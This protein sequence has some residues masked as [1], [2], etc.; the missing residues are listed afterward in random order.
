VV[1]AIR[2]AFARAREE[3]RAALVPFLTAG[4][5]DREACLELLLGMADVGADVVELGVPFSDP[6]ADGPT[7]QRASERALAGGMSLAGALDL[8]AAFR[9]RRE[10]P[11]V[12]FTY[13]NPVLRR[14]VSATARELAR[15]GA[16]GVLVCDLPAGEA[17]EVRAEFR[18][19][20]L[21][22]VAL[23]AP[24]SPEARLRSVAA[25]SSGF[26]YLIGRT[27]VTGAG[28]A[29]P[30]LER[31]LAALRRLTDLPV[32][33]GFGIAG[34]ESARAVARIADG[35]VVGSALLDRIDGAGPRAG[36]DFLR[37][38]RAALARHAARP[39]V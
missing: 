25:A 3:G 10:T 13:L 18:A 2:A 39:P 9:R 1:S 27:G 30:R 26:L 12:V 4:Y 16:D 14:G 28:G 8:A 35:V 33:V 6:V 15:V 11:L 38:V 34:P 36:L 5:P 22:Y 37:S 31:Q 19:A 29:Y 7:I 20:G 21:D 32:A 24:T 23:A 17:P